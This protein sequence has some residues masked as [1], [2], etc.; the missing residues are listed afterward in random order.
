MCK[1][2]IELIKKY[3]LEE[4]IKFVIVG[5]IA[6][7]INYIVYLIFHKLVNINIA[8]TLGY[9]ISF[10]FNLIA[11]HL[12]T[13]KKKVNSKSSFRF[14]LAHLTNYLIQ[15]ALL[16]LFTLINVPDNLAP[17]PVYII[18]I[19]INFLT[20]RFAIKFNK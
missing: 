11:S 4:F 6:T 5:L 1:D 15:I 13:F 10:C 9:I 12:F 3:K 8:Y 18:A 16:N 20:V 7:G 19:P 14:L 2:I 17:I